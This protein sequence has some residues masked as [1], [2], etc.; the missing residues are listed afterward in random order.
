[1]AYGSGIVT[2]LFGRRVGLQTMSSAVTGAT[3]SLPQEFLV[4]P[5]CIRYG[6]TTNETTGTPMQASGISYLVGTSAASTPIFQ[7]VAV[8]R[9]VAAHPDP[10]LVGKGGSPLGNWPKFSKVSSTR[11]P[12]RPSPEGGPCATLAQPHCTTWYH[13]DFSSRFQFNRKDRIRTC[14]S[15]RKRSSKAAGN[16]LQPG[17]L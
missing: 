7:L 11:R 6:V 12:E 14:R 13:P 8:R 10:E 15:I 3:K 9:A 4:G 5:E 2:S 16:R 17:V 1:M